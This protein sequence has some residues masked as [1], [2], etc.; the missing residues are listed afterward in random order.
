MFAGGIDVSG[1]AWSGGGDITKVEVSVDGGEVWL[2]ADIVREQ[3]A[4]RY[5]PVQW[6]IPLEFEPG[7]V[8]LMSRATDSSGATQPLRSRWNTGGYANNVVQRITF[9]I[10]TEE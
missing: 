6:T 9:D 4:G 3:T 1:S 10:A 2:E 7:T 5:A 8:E